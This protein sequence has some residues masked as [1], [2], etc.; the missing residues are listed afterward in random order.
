MLQ[1]KNN[2]APWEEKNFK[3]GSLVLLTHNGVLRY[4]IAVHWA[5]DNENG[6]VYLEGD[7][8][9]TNDHQYVR[10]AKQFVGEMELRY[11]THSD[12]ISATQFK[13]LPVQV[14]TDGANHFFICND[15]NYSSAVNVVS[16]A[17]GQIPKG[18]VYIRKW[19]IAV[20]GEKE[21]FIQV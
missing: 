18:L 14:A 17:A 7:A 2:F 5:Y 20:P 6:F 12:D 4:A 15:G 10:V 8:A 21:P 9:G 3:L 13:A 16:G 19:S 1:V 11:S